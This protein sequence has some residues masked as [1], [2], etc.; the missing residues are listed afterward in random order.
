MQVTSGVAYAF[1]DC[2]ATKNELEAHVPLARQLVQTPSELELRLSEGQQSVLHDKQ[3]AALVE[4]GGGWN[5]TLQAHYPAQPNTAAAEELAVIVNQLY[6]SPL[7]RQG[8]S[9][10]VFLL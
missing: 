3:L 10:R 8:G 4:Q 2:T 6:Q 9:F 1:F 7:Y 5:Y